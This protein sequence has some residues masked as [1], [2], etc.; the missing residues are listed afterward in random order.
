MLLRPWLKCARQWLTTA[1]AVVGMSASA[2]NS[3]DSGAAPQTQAAPPTVGIVVLQERDTVLTTELPGRVA[4]FESSE[5]RPQVTG[6]IEKRLF[7]EGQMVK[8][9][10][11]LYQIDARL[12]RAAYA[13]AQ[14]DLRGA[15]ATAAAAKEKATR[16]QTL[17]AEGLATA[18]ELTEVNALANQAAARVE[19]ARA[20]VETARIQLAFTQVS[21]P[22][23]GRIGRSM[24]T[25]GALVTAGQPAA[26]AA[27][28]R[29]DPMFIDLQESSS[30]ITELRRSL[31]KGG[32]LPASTE[33]KVRLED[34]TIYEHTGTLQFSEPMVDPN[35]G[36][37]T[38]RATFPNPNQELLPGMYVRAVV[39]QGTRPRAILAPQQGIARDQRGQPIAYVVGPSDTIEYREVVAKR[40]IGDEWLI[41]SGLRAG[42]RL[43]VEGTS[44]VQPG[45]RVNP[46]PFVPQAAA[47]GV[48]PTSGAGAP[49]ASAVSPAVS[50]PGSERDPAAAPTASGTASVH[51]E[52]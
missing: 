4:A 30:V 45:L 42:D 48:G 26:L 3:K 24:V 2:C 29:L 35:T 13:Q 41:E 10:E 46:V 18:L 22:I 27:I 47:S 19:Q 7:T 17:S 12:Y 21:A 8:R 16:F 50:V 1:A 31:A 49:G 32:M 23:Q 25:T 9:G 43:V 11:T 39:E 6:I 36:S 15:E 38:V 37:V 34:G 20:A 14:A 52:R 33:V 44:K 40:S 51:G 5:V 28:Q